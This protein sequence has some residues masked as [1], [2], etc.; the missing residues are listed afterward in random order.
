MR[1]L[2]LLV[3]MATTL[4][5]CAASLEGGSVDALPA[6]GSA[7]DGIPYRLRDQLVVEVYKLTDEGYVPV[8]KQVEMLADPTRLYMLNFDGKALSDAG[9]KIEQRPDGTLV[10]VG[11]TSTGKTAEAAAA[12]SSGIDA[13][14]AAE[15][16]LA[17]IR[18]AEV[19]A[20]DAEDA[21]AK[22][23]LTASAQEQATL[24][25]N[26]LAALRARDEVVRLQRK[27]AEDRQD[28]KPSEA[29]AAESAIR[30]AK[31]QANTAAVLTGL[32]IPYPDIGE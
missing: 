32:P 24:A 27:L 8:G 29:F 6:A 7:V 4:T 16:T 26:Q 1:R 10:N 9:L 31:M 21:K 13:L 25:Q 17:D 15:K 18:K 14:V 23:L 5:G 22:A 11:L 2:T 30:V 20:T 28:L 19:A 12:V 3:A